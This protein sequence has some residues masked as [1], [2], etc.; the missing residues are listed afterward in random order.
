MTKQ[1]ERDYPLK[2][3]QRH[4]YTKPFDDA[5][6]LREFATAL[7]LLQ[8]ALPVHGSILDMGCG[9]GWTSLLLARAGFEVHGIDISERMIEIARER[10]EDERVQ[11][12]FAVADMEQ[13]AL[14]RRDFDGALLFD[15]LHHC[16]AYP[17]VLRRAWEHLK[18][19]GCLL[20]LEPS[21]LHLYSPHARQATRT[22]GVTELGFTRLRLAR[23]LRRA[24]FR[25]ITSYYDGGAAYRGVLG[26]LLANLRLWCGYLCCYPRIKQILLARKDQDAVTA[27]LPT[28]P[29]AHGLARVGSR[30]VHEDSLASRSG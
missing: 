17:E 15:S 27:P 26:F 4:L 19:G 8:R 24:G 7:E 5:R 13:F 14:D 11:A 29:A 10:A 25:Q 28:S 30:K 16:P 23:C 2:V 9:S 20:L 22:Y 6:M 1:A 18:P 12:T 3:D 21:W